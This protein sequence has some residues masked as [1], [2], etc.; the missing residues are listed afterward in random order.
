MPKS[1][2]YRTHENRAM[3]LVVANVVFLPLLA[4]YNQ[5]TLLIGLCLGQASEIVLGIAGLY[6][7]IAD[8]EITILRETRE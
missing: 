8:G 2:L 7:A 1:P 3:F 4:A 5:W 6:M